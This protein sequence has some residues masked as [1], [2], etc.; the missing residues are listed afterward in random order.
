MK[1]Y[2]LEENEETKK[3][4]HLITIISPAGAAAIAAKLGL[5]L[6]YV[7]KNILPIYIAKGYINKVKTGFG[8]TVYK[9]NL[10]V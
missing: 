8:R 5:S 9:S 1:I 6:D 10:E 7:R 4:L 3:R 2:E